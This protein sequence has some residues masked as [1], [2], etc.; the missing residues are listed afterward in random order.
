MLKLKNFLF[1]FSLSFLSVL[2]FNPL[3]LAEDYITITTY[4]PSPYGAYNKLQSNKLAVGD[5]NADSELNSSDL[6]S[7]DG[8]IYAARS[9]ILKPQASLPDSDELTGELVYK[10]SDKTLYHYDGSAWAAV[11][12]STSAGVTALSA[13]A[14][15]TYTF[16]NAVGYCRDL[17]AAAAVSMTGD[18]TTV[19]T[20]WHLPSIPEA[21]VFVGSTADTSECW[22]AFPYN[23]SNWWLLNYSTGATNC[24]APATPYAVRCVR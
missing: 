3:A 7:A 13:E 5:T 6:P 1:F 4:Y 9:I 17:S 14:A 18:T 24:N 12:A 11:G 2:I 20:D 21:A 15:S 16:P 22:V 19:Y 8:Q 23:T 10:N